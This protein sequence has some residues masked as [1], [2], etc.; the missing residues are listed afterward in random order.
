M[1]PTAQK[2]FPKEGHRLYETNVE[3]SALLEQA[4][5]NEV[6]IM[7]MGRPDAPEGRLALATA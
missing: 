7:V 4:G 3:V 2:N 1:P 5:F 6:R